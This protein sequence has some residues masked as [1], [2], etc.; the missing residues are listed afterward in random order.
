MILFAKGKYTDISAQAF[1]GDLQFSKNTFKK[2]II[3]KEEQV[4]SEEEI[5]IVTEYLHSKKSIR[6]LGILLAFQTG[7]RVGELAAIRKGDIVYEE[8]TVSIHI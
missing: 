8:G 2:K 7:I 6:C 3:K 1:F 5:P 4:F